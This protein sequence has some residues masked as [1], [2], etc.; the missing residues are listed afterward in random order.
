VPPEST[1]EAIAHVIQL[2]VAPVFLLA[3]VAS[4]LNVLTGRLARIVDRIR[5]LEQR[6]A[7]ADEAQ[8]VRLHAEM[9]SLYYRAG[10][11]NLSLS[12]CTT[13]AL[14]V[15]AVIALLF[16]GAVLSV[17]ASGLIAAIFISAMVALMAGLLGFLREVYL[18]TA[19]LRLESQ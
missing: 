19:G 11:V 2:S 15:C 18:A 5:S 6:L 12:L 10:V 8:A 1:V 14:L 3:G 9:K 16:V 7:L 4:M 13:C 17:D